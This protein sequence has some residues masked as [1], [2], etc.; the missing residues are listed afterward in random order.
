MAGPTGDQDEDQKGDGD[1]VG[2]RSRLT[3]V[4]GALT[5]VYV[6]AAALDLILLGTD[7]V[8]FNRLHLDLDGLGPRLV[9]AVLCAAVV[10]HAADGLGRAV[11]DLRPSLAG[12][13]MAAAVAGR[14]VGTAA[15]VPVA[16]AVVWPAVRTWWVR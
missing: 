2:G 11:V 1:R 3:T 12:R 4:A 6:V 16:V 7:P 9:V 5:L 8:R 13:R 10:L 14:F 15:A